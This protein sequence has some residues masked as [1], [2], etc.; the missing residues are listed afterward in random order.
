MLSMKPCRSALA[1]SGYGEFI[2]QLAA[3]RGNATPRIP[4]IANQI[5]CHAANLLYLFQAYSLDPL[6]GSGKTWDR[7]SP[8]NRKLQFCQSK[9]PT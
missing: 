1:F 6:A 3:H 9:W 4:A 7:P 2:R 8:A 5:A